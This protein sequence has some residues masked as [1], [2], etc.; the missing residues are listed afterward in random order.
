MAR[1]PTCDEKVP[2]E[3]A[4]VFRE[5]EEVFGMVPNLFLTYAHHPPLLRSNWEKVKAILMQ[6]R[7]SRTV[8]EAIAIVISR[9]NRSDYCLATHT[10]DMLAL[11]F[12]QE[13]IDVLPDDLDRS[14]F[15]PKEKALI[16]FARDANRAPH[17]IDDARVDALLEAGADHAEIVE[18]LGVMELFA[19]FNKFLVASDV[20]MEFR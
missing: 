12:T 17:D 20:D 18:A 4:D 2:K 16:A 1:I 10:G 13:E 8:K 14:R 9:D 6:G 11:G 19:A 3:A 7:L 15:S 5:I